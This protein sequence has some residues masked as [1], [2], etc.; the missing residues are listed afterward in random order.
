LEEEDKGDSRGE[1][2]IIAAFLTAAAFA[3]PAEP[4][5]AA[6][7][8]VP[9]EDLRALIEAA[10]SRDDNDDAEVV[11]VL[12]R[13]RVLVEDSGLAHYRRR[14]VLKA[15]SEKGATELATLRFDYDPASNQVELTG[16]RVYRSGGDAVEEIP[17][18]RARDLPQPQRH[19]YWGPRM[20]VL[21]VP[22]LAPGDAV[23]VE[24]Y[25]KGFIIALLGGTAS[26]VGADA[27]ERYIPPMRG[28]FYATVLFGDA[29]FPTREQRYA[30]TLPRDKPL[31]FE[32]YNGELF[33]RFEYDEQH[34]TY[35]WW[36]ENL[37]PHPSEPHA[38]GAD[39]YLPKVVMSTAADWQ[40][41]SRW[42]FEVNEDQFEANDAI[43]AKLAEITAGATT[44]D[45][46]I[47]AILHWTAQE[48]RYSGISMGKG[49]GYVLHSGQTTL[50]DR[51]GVCKDIAGMS[52]TLLRAAG[53]SSYPAMTMAGSRVERV[54]ADQFNH[55][56]VAVERPEG[57]RMLD[58]TWAPFSAELWSSAEREQHYLIGTPEGADL[59]V[60]PYLPPEHNTL[61]F[62]ARSR[63]DS[64]GDLTS[65]VAILGNGYL[66]DG[67]RRWVAGHTVAELRP[68]I[69]GLLARVAP[70]ATL[71]DLRFGDHRDLKTPFRIEMRYS[72]PGYAVVGKNTMRTRIPAA[73]HLFGGPRT[74][75]WLTATQPEK[76]V[77]AIWLRSPQQVTIEET[78]QVPAGMRLV[79]LP[80]DEKIET[81]IGSMRATVA[82]V[83][84]ALS[85]QEVLRITQR[86]IAPDNYSGLKTVADAFRALERR[87]FYL[88]RGGQP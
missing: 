38:A 9:P 12:D 27:D 50:N 17:S 52:I 62:T 66:E 79:G 76:R 68:S 59:M 58:P 57:F 82:Q 32:V 22:R 44:D 77:S 86:N 10:G 34:H 23:E 47:D 63:I 36:R 7:I 70:N 8:D 53:F 30:V 18:T 75:D 29:P 61:Q 25:T 88:Q 3:A 5:L 28:H 69:Q 64:S 71:L 11:V 40:S 56:V 41:K 83:G 67:M 39:D 15:L 31:Q 84:G 4:P 72:V 85:L 65:H 2:M 46:R 33:S 60:T 1:I 19:I 24:T 21:S 26:G 54:P 73:S 42:F 6:P 20:K 48:I 55:C 87:R 43:R 14:R 49:E 80:V 74:T 51:A 35:S 37:P 78:L 81:A 13:T 45:E 16:A